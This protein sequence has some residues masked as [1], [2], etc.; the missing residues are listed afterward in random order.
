MLVRTLK[1]NVYDNKYTIT[2]FTGLQYEKLPENVSVCEMVVGKLPPVRGFASGGQKSL[3]GGKMLG[4]NCRSYVNF[5]NLSKG[6]FEYGK[7]IQNYK[8]ASG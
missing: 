4:Y 1:T 3:D 8:P 6:F 2:F 7:G 5:Y